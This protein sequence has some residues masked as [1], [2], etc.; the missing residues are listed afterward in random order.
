[1]TAA[2]AH[3]VL[4]LL[5]VRWPLADLP[6][7]TPA[8]WEQDLSAVPVEAVEAAIREFA[9]SGREFPPTSGMVAAKLIERADQLPD[10]DEMR[11]EA[12]RLL[13]RGFSHDRPPRPDDYSHP[14]LATFFA[15][16]GSLAWREF[17]LAS[18]GDGTFAAQQR[19]AYKALCVRVHR[20]RSLGVIGAPRPSRRGLQRPDFA[21]ALGDGSAS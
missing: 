10:H 1:M 20:D 8:L 3:K 5:R 9:I 19:D 7:E 13:R 6:P 15:A 14:V 12:F 21:G 17:C 4:A 2:E 18:E 16:N 11:A